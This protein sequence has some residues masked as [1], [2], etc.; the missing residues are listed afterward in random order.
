LTA[1]SITRWSSSSH[2]DTMHWRS[3]YKIKVAQ[4]K[5]FLNRLCAV[6]S[7]IQTI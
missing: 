2:A 7:E 5:S 1:V 6:L 4:R 3:S